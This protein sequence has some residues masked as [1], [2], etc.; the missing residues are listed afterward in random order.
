MGYFIKKNKAL[1]AS[2][3]LKTTVEQE[4]SIDQEKQD[5]IVEDTL[6]VHEKREIK[7]MVTPV[8]NQNVIKS[9]PTTLKSGSVTKVRMEE[10]AHEKSGNDIEKTVEPILKKGLVAEQKKPILKKGTVVVQKDVK[11]ENVNFFRKIEE[12]SGRNLT[13]IYDQLTDKDNK[14]IDNLLSL[15]NRITRELG[16]KDITRSF[17]DLKKF[18][19]FI[20]GKT[21]ILV[22]N[23]SDLLNHKNGSLIDS[24]D[25]VVRF[26]SFKID[27]EHTGNKT[28]I[29]TSVYL[30]DINLEYFVPIRFIVSINLTNWVNKIESIGKFNQGLLLKYNHHNEIKGQQKDKRPTTTGFVMLTLLLKLGGFKELN[31]I[32]FN[33]YEGGMDS[34]LR[35]DEGVA[36]NI[37]KVHDYN[38]EKSMIMAHA[39][40]YDD[41]NNIITF[42][43]NSTL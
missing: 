2:K 42:Y 17:I 37:S 20:K 14:N 34:I 33:F 30:Q 31:L 41:K 27:P 1:I 16:K 7:K 25:I 23:S 38:F 32:G 26:N 36:L 43:D 21:I 5:K 28:T 22:A 6:V 19:S 24:H 35:T 39:N 8:V 3:L 9:E 29:H 40:K 13:D 4:V 10:P 18:Q 12:T 15:G 11:I